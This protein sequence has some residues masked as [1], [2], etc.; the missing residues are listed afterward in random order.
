MELRARDLRFAPGEVSAFLKGVMGLTLDVR[1]LEARVEG[2]VTGLQLAA[3]SMRER[4]NPSELIAGLS[5]SHHYFLSYLTE[6]VLGRLPADT[7]SFVLET[8]VLDRMTGVLLLRCHA[9]GYLLAAVALTKC[10]V[11]GLALVA[12]IIGQLV[13]GVEVSAVEAVIFGGI[14]TAGLVMATLMLRSVREM[15]DFSGEV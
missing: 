6:E 4:D 8:S 1:E 12:I 9:L 14:A 11:M 10:A 2:W 7:R 15:S 5:G 3:L 13:A